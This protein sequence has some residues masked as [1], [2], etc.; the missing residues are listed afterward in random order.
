MLFGSIAVQRSMEDQGLK[1]HIFS[2]QAGQRKQEFLQQD[3]LQ[4]YVRTS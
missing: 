3:L 4:H 2:G 1:G